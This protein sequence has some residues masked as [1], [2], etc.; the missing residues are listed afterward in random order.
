LKKTTIKDVAKEAG[1]SYA[2]VSNVINNK[3]RM[4]DDTKKRVQRAIKKLNF[5]PDTTAAALSR[6]RTESVAFISSYLSSPFVTSVLSGAE[7]RLYETG[8]LNNDIVHYATKG[9]DA[10]KTTVIEDILYGKKAGAVIVLTMT[11]KPKLVSEFKKRGIPL[12]LVESRMKGVHSVRADN[13]QGAYD[14]VKHLIKSGR[15]K[16]AIITGP[17]RPSELDMDVSP[18]EI[19][20]LE[21]Y[22]KALSEHGISFRHD[23]IIQVPFY[24]M[25]EGMKCMQEMAKGRLKYDAVFCAAGDNVAYGIIE[26][27]KQLGIK[28]PSDMA[29]AGYDDTEAARACRPSI[30]TVKQPLYEMGR[31]AF[32]IA[33][34]GMAGSNKGV[35]DKVLKSNLIIR[36]SA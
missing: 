29:I 17:L 33:I 30:T 1:I 4:S 23:S 13:I 25:E 5:F 20:R 2:T 19:E 26:A 10:L 11:I 34:N 18:A 9:T 22:K 3:G 28:I 8:K 27:G 24:N 21:G 12:V 14:A 36:E 32:D 15:R 6:G 7:S 31:E 35:V 16:I